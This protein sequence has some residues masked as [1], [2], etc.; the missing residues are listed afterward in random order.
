M[1]TRYCDS[2]TV[3]ELLAEFGRVA[4]GA[5]S[6]E[7]RATV[8]LLRAA[9]RDGTALDACWALQQHR[10]DFPGLFDAELYHAAISLASALWH[11]ETGTDA[12]PAIGKVFAHCHAALGSLPAPTGDDRCTP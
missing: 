4:A 3:R 7:V 5:E 8:G 12:G 10:G 9:L 1:G 11:V 6:P 2:A